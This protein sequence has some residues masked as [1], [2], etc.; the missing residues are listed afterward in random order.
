MSG[1]NQARW[2]LVLAVNLLAIAAILGVAELGVRWFAADAEG[3]EQLPMCRPD[4]RT[5]WRYRPNVALTYRAPG[6]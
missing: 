1:K 4:T 5:V 3:D 2:T 6:F